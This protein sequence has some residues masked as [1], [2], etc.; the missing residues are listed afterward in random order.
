MNSRYFCAVATFFAL[1]GCAAP[2][3]QTSF[4]YTALAPTK[5][6]MRD[7]L[8]TPPPNPKAYAASTAAKKEELLYTLSLAQ[9]DALVLCNKQ[10]DSLRTWVSEQ[11]RI[12]LTP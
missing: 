12:Y 8:L 7:C 3:E 2:K 1:M 6:M 9:M 10:W 4:H 5:E 11:Q